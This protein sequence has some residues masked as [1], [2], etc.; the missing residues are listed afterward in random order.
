MLYCGN[1]V[2]TREATATGTLLR[3]NVQPT[4]LLL[5]S[6]FALCR[7][8]LLR[9][10]F[11]D[12][13]SLDILRSPRLQKLSKQVMSRRGNSKH[14]KTGRKQAQNS[15][16]HERTRS[17]WLCVL[18]SATCIS[19]SIFATLYRS[20]CDRHHSRFACGVGRCKWAVLAVVYAARTTKWCPKAVIIS[21][22]WVRVFCSY[23]VS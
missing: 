22:R 4:G 6:D 2:A 19:L 16:Y 3:S 12:V 15:S 10:Q 1:G 13:I 21:R 5:G 9:L 18:Q 8:E 23:A 7:C 17:G 11:V 20:S 14:R